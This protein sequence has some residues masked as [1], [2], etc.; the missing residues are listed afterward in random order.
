MT[1]ASLRIL[2]AHCRYRQ[3]GGE[4][5]V[6][7]AEADLLERNGHA[8]LRYTRDNREIDGI[9]RVALA[10][11]TLWS[12]RTVRDLERRVRA[13]RPHVI[14]VHNTFP[15]LSPS[16]YWAAARAGV[17]VVQTLHN[18]RLL[19]A[20]AMLLKDGAVCERCI[21]RLPWRGV[22]GRCYRDSATQSAVLVGGLA[23]HRALGTYRHKAVRY[24][25]LS[26]FCRRKFIE[27]GLPP[28]R[29]V[30]KP[31]FVDVRC[32]PNDDRRGG[33]FVGRL[34]PEKG[35][36]VLAEALSQRPWSAIDVIGTGP[37]RSRLEGR[38]SVRLLDWQEPEVIYR[39]MRRAAYLVM[40]SI[41]FENFPR[42]LVEAF[43]CGLPVIASR[44]GALAELIDDGRTGLLFEPGSA[45]D[46]ARRLEWAETHLRE[47]RLM[48]VNA[49]Y[50]YER[51]YTPAINYRQLVDIYREALGG[52]KEM[53]LAG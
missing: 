43:A 53:A 5:A 27:G 8:V 44:L 25:A 45:P 48:G 14:H 34:A 21:G 33:L 42:T 50:E 29:I 6:A 1:A 24:I 2:I 31:N 23:L 20:Q 41:W 30:V 49:R 3:R 15:L 51:K 37:E 13:F 4:D 40:P 46:L 18:F 10:V 26:E 32:R 38:R 47:L 16:I 22:V 52:R 9:D 19:C 11:Q 7:D 28:E 39:A 12:T 36:G 35:V 17:P